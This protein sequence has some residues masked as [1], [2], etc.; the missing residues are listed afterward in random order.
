M[1]RLLDFLCGLIMGVVTCM[2]TKKVVDH[3][4]RKGTIGKI[5]DIVKEDVKVDPVPEP[6]KEEV[7]KPASEEKVAA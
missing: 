7:K 1:G 5:V 3:N 2:V 4:K 6:V